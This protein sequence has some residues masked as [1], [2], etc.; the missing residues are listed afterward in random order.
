MREE[1]GVIKREF[2]RNVIIAMVVI[3]IVTLCLITEIQTAGCVMV[4]IIF[5]LLDVAGFAHYWGLKY[6]GV[7]MIYSLIAL[8]LTVVTFAL[9]FFCPLNENFFM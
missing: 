8:G 5:S 3:A 6:N 7:V 4:A 9:V 1:F 2:L